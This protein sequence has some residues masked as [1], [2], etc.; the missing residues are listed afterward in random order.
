MMVMVYY[1][2]PA[3]YLRVKT[4]DK[5]CLTANSSITEQSEKKKVLKKNNPRIFV[6][7]KQLIYHACAMSKSFFYSTSVSQGDMGA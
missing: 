2:L 5:W 3:Y 4:P 1:T 6:F 7:R